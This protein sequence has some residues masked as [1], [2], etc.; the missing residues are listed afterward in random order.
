MNSWRTL[1]LA[2]YLRKKLFVIISLFISPHCFSQSDSLLKKYDQQLLY[3]Y[4]SHFMKGGNK[5]SF[6]ALR[7]EFPYAS[8][9]S[10]LYA[11]AK[12]DKTISTVLRFASILAIVGVAKGASDNNRNLTYGFMAGQLVTIFASRAF[13]DKSILETDKA[14]QLRNRELL[15]PG[16]Q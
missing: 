12:K 16:R 4:G 10:D 8:I 1:L 7:E 9:S 13:H 14:I 15:F 11:K 2:C 5:V 6:S 3:R